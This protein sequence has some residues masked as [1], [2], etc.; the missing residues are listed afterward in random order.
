MAYINGKA[1]AARRYQL[2][3]QTLGG[4]MTDSND[5]FDTLPGKL[6]AS[7]NDSNVALDLGF[8][9][10]GIY[11]TGS[12]IGALNFC[13]DAGNLSAGNGIRITQPVG[14]TDGI[15]FAITGSH[16]GLS[17]VSGGL[18][19]TMKLDLGGLEVAAVTVSDS[20]AFA[21]A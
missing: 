11:A 7:N 10:A 12:I 5:A 4:M 1:S 6:Q 9:A 18:G 16:S 17:F 19:D 13:Y 20:I 21:D 14:E 2:H 8:A 15:I 3:L